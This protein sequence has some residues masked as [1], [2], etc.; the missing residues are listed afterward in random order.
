MKSCTRRFAV[1]NWPASIERGLLGSA[2]Y[3]VEAIY[4]CVSRAERR[5]IDAPRQRNG[6]GSHVHALL[7]SRTKT[8]RFA[9]D[10]RAAETSSRVVIRVRGLHE[11][12][13]TLEAETETREGTAS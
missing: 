3:F 12:I 1:L 7:G 4:L 2:N 10:R 11:L 6:A 8:P 13:K 5:W 9:S